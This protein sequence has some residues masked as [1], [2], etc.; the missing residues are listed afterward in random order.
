M[1]TTT[2]PRHPNPR[3]ALH[4]P[5]A[6]AHSSLFADAWFAWHSMPADGPHYTVNTA[7]GH[8]KS[9]QTAR[10]QVHDVV[11]ANGTVIYNNVCGEM[12][13]QWGTIAAPA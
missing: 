13:V 1:S 6:T 5:H 2:R 7:T 12:Q 3:N 9:E 10:T 11:S 4:V 8:G